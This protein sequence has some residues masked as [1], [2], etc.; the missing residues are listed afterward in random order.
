MGGSDALT[1]CVPKCTSIG[2]CDAEQRQASRHPDRRWG[3]IQQHPSSSL[4]LALILMYFC[5]ISISFICFKFYCS[6]CNVLEEFIYYWYELLVVFYF[7]PSCL[8]MLLF[9]PFL[10]FFLPLFFHFNVSLLFLYF[11]FTFFYVI[12]AY[13]YFS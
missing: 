11:T 1:C 2:G 3:C 10:S 4:M 12:S 13:G 6:S 8:T 7:W 9:L 5:F